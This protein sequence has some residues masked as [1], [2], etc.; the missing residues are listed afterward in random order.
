MNTEEFIAQ[1]KKLIL[2]TTID[3]E[4]EEVFTNAHGC[5]IT[6]ASGRKYLDASAQVCIAKIGHNHPLF[7]EHFMHFLTEAKR[8]DYI[9]TIIGS[10]F[11]W[12]TGRPSALTEF[13]KNTLET[14][15]S[16]VSLANRLAPL[17]FG[18]EDTGFRFKVS[19]TEATSDAIRDCRTVTRKPFVFAFDR[20]FH[21]RYGEAKDASSSNPTHWKEAPRDGLTF[22]LPYPETDEDYK[23][24]MEKLTGGDYPLDEF[25]CAIYEPIQGEGGGMRIGTYLQAVDLFLKEQNII[26]IGD[27]IQTGLGQ[28]GA[29]FT[30][31]LLG[32]DP[33]ILIIG[34]S[35]G[36]GFSP[37]YI[38]G[39]RK[40]KL[41]ISKIPRSKVGG[42]STMGVMQIVV[43]H[44][45][46]SVF[47]QC[48][49]MKRADRAGA[50]LSD[51]LRSTVAPFDKDDG[52][53]KFCKIDGM[54]LF[55]SIKPLIFRGMRGGI[56]RY[57]P[58]KA[59]VKRINRRLREL[60]I[61]TL[62]AAREEA[63]RLSPP[64]I[65]DD[66]GITHLAEA[67]GAAIRSEFQ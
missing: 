60:G 43:A 8:Y 24:L 6:A 62:T 16:P 58:D 7:W 23:I 5:W 14:M 34:K 26:T 27:E 3:P 20:G 37:I 15:H 42:T 2:P 1:H 44:V 32:A 40:N 67:V 63:I 36:Y 17:F 13:E 50:L 28:C 4:E 55:R 41:D 35:P 11:Y 30:S 38:G 59:A 12:A 18:E 47:E 10:D 65:I 46:L 48:N 33:D 56:P 31:R 29:W 21:G 25:A 54:G 64:L 45:V 9:T 39:Y 51:A 66:Q 49:I 22:F 57:Q 53:G 19:G 52:G 61:L